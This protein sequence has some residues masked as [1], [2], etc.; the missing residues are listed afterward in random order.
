[1][2][3][4]TYLRTSCICVLKCEVDGLVLCCTDVEDDVHSQSFNAACR[5]SPSVLPTRT[6]A[7]AS[8][9]AHCTLDK[10]SEHLTSK[11]YKA[12]MQ[13]VAFV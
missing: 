5:H 9:A 8:L 1:M 4:E 7:G 2:E 10:S 13:V 3:Y 11:S 12:R 6:R